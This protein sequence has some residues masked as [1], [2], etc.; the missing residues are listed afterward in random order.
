V[1]DALSG[2]ALHPA[3]TFYYSWNWKAALLSAMLRA[4]IFLIATIRRGAE[5]ISIAVLAEAIYSSAISGC[6]L[7]RRGALHQPNRPARPANPTFASRKWCP[8]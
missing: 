7:S 2:L 6:F 4:P 1:V 5:A 3:Q 8:P